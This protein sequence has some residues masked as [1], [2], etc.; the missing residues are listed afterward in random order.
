MVM[1]G[2]NANKSLQVD[3]LS[4][5]YGPSSSLDGRSIVTCSSADTLVRWVWGAWMVHG[6]STDAHSNLVSQMGMGYMD[7]PWIPVGNR[8]V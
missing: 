8:L 1:D 7:Y 2:L 5:G 6:W 4:Q 3:T